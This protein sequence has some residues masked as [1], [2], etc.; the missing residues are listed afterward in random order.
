MSDDNHLREHRIDSA[1]VFDGKLLHVKRDHVRLPDGN[2]ATREY[3]RH[4]GAV[5][6]VPVFDDGTLLVE[7][8]F[9][10]PVGE[11]ML[12]FPAGKLDSGESPRE[13]ALREL[14]EETGYSAQHCEHFHVHHPTIGYSTE[15]ITCFIAKG[16]VAGNTSLDDG[17]FVETQRIS[18]SELLEC[19]KNGELTDGKTVA[20][21]FVAL[22]LQ[23]ISL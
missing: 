12:E 1:V 18:V 16:L 22:H 21:L 10:Y 9:R 14:R 19:V 6:I 13:A 23:L 3:V 11:V 4:P 2:I 7:R 15:R 17:E 20:G 8:Q 5:M